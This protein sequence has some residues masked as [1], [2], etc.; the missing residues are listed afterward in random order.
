V[1]EAIAG[2]L[3]CNV[4][5]ASDTQSNKVGIGVCVKDNNGKFVLAKN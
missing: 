5:A 1:D 2:R 4:D 3:K